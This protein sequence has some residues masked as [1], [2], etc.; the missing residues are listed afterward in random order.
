MTERTRSGRSRKKYTAAELARTMEAFEPREAM[1]IV[2][3]LTVPMS[4]I[5]HGKHPGLQGAAL[6]DLLAM[7]VAGHHPDEREMVLGA[8]M[9][10]TRAL[11]SMHSARIGW[12]AELKKEKH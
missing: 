9:N 10:A 11:V 12:D 5:L 1:A 8:I 4:E 6:I 2:D 3:D 7:Y